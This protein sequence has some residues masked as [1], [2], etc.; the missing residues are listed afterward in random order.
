MT[1]EEQ[2]HGERGLRDQIGRYRTAF[3][4]VVAMV[5]IA[6]FVGGYILSHE[7]LSLP[8]WFPVLGKNYVTL[9]ADFRTAQ[10]VTPGQGQA[11]TIAGA[12]IGEIASVK[13]DEGDALVT[14]NVEPKYAKYIY[15]DATMLLRPKTG[16]KD[17]T[18]EVDPG[19]P[20]AGS[21]P[22]SYT[23]PRSQTAPDVN[24]E[25]FLSVF[26]AETRAYLQELLAGAGE[27]LKGNSANLSAT[28]K[29]FDPIALYTRKITAQLQLRSKNI[30]R[31]IHNFQLIVSALGDK[32][33]ELAQAIDASNAVFQTFAEQ[34]QSFE[35]TLHLLPGTLAKAKS[36]LGK[37]AT[38]V[39]VTGSTLTKLDPF[40]KELGPA[41][42]ATRSL[43]KQSTP[44][45]KNQLRPFAREILPVVNQLQ[46]SLK[47]L[48]EAFPGLESSFAVFN[49]FLNELSYNPGT[50]KGG[51]MSF[52]LWANHDLN[53]V[54]SSA[55]AHGPV[56]R[57]L[58]YLNCGVLKNLQGA[59]EVN[60]AVKLLVALLDP[61][62]KQECE[63]HGLS[64]VTA[65][66]AA[67]RARSHST[68]RGGLTLKLLGSKNSAFG[69]LAS[70]SGGGR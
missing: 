29:R 63:A 34:Q 2:H 22:S 70:A 11:V 12:K 50:N 33:T 31:A 54:I 18:V 10:A 55:D 4:S 13:S 57:T 53:S 28:F 26:D 61:P 47:E 7:R 68:P 64:E 14:M 52:L 51:F 8:G 69:K 30:E 48:G 42:E 39:G 3:I 17:M 36:G 44:I 9:K 15:R 37:L 21:I 66:A 32:D 27:G 65:G 23:V 35:K 62:S 46:P 19:T 6:L 1:P 59:T 20:S 67:A 58:L 5:V 40:A 16:L 56:G 45:F 41:Q 24:F 43:F 25:E 49:E 60:K 38:A